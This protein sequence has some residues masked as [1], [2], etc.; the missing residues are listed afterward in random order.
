M[1]G[2]KHSDNVGEAQALYSLAKTVPYQTRLY[3]IIEITVAVS[4]R[5]NN[6]MISSS[7]LTTVLD[8]NLPTFQLDALVFLKANEAKAWGTSIYSYIEATWCAS[9][10]IDQCWACALAVQF[11]MWSGGYGPHWFHP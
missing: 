1:S 9:L 2:S 8:N 11:T 10:L 4:T 6:E 3:T 5:T 7:S